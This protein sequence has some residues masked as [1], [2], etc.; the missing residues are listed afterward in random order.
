MNS[1]TALHR[2]M[3]QLPTSGNKQHCAPACYDN[4]DA[5][6]RVGREQ[7]TAGVVEMLPVFMLCNSAPVVFVA[8]KHAC[9]QTTRLADAV[10]ATKTGTAKRLGAPWTLG[11]ELCPT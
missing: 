3:R 8:A 4:D 11:A 1:P 5:A 7:R 2:S 6:T 9:A 10:F